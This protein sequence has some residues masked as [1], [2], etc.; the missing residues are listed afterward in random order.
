MNRKE[1][2]DA[3]T[4]YPYDIKTKQIFV[5]ES[6]NKTTRFFTHNDRIFVFNSDF[7][8]ISD[9]GFLYSDFA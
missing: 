3:D 9:T 1:V 8:S 6:L 4:F 5:V 7:T 2:F